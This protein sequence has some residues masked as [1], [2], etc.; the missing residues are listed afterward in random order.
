MVIALS[1]IAILLLISVVS[2]R[3]FMSDMAVVEKDLINELKEVKGWL[4]KIN[5]KQL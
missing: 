5:E 4:I 1:V 3:K 2:L